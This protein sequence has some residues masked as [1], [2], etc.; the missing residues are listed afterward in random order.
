MPDSTS[1]RPDLHQP[2]ATDPLVAFVAQFQ[3]AI[4]SGDAELFNRSFAQDVRWGSPFGAVVSGYEAIHA[5]HTQMFARLRPVAG[6]WRYSLEE[7]FQPAPDVAIGYIRRQLVDTG[8]AQEI[9]LGQR[10]DE[11]ALVVLIQREGEWWLS[12]AQHVPDRREIYASS[13][14]L[15]PV[16]T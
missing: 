11:L 2:V 13:E 12:A 8:L 15:K 14:I 7:S 3:A 10:F 4:D 5:I 16:Q 9:A 1:P 6:T